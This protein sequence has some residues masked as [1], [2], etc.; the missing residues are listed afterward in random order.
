MAA[1]FPFVTPFVDVHAVFQWTEQLGASGGA[2]GG[3][4]GS[5]PLLGLA[6]AGVV[7]GVAVIYLVR[8]RNTTD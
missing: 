8:S 1:Q 3:D 4:G 6:L 2:G 7:V 5:L